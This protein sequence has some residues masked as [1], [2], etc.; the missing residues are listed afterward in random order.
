M[1]LN[2]L[3]AMIFTAGALSACSSSNSGNDFDS[4]I[5]NV[6]AAG[7]EGENIQ[8]IAVEDLPDNASLS[9]QLG[10]GDDASDNFFVGDATATADFSAGTLTGS[11]TNF[12]EFEASAACAEGFDGC[13]GT[14]LQDVDGDIDITGSITG[15]EFTYNA[16]GELSTTDDGE[17]VTINADLDD[18]GVFGTLDGG[19]V[20]IAGGEGTAVVTS[21]AGSETVDVTGVLYLE[22]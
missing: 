16:N 4:L 10:A 18:S 2:A 22:E 19:L 17:A 7:G 14:A 12:T 9:G 1:K 15:T 3:T 8:A 5:S 6:V 20:A 21:S 13:T 11:A